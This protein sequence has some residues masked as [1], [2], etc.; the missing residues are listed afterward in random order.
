MTLG[1]RNNQ[2]SFIITITRYGLPFVIGIFYLTA[3]L[4]FEFTADSTMRMASIVKFGFA[5]SIADGYPS[6]LWQFLLRLGGWF[7][8]DPLLTSKV[9]SLVFSCLAV[10]ISYLVANEILRDRL[11]AFCVSLVL[12]MQG[13]LLQIAPSGSALSMAIALTLTALF[14]MLRNEYVVAPFIL[15]LC[16]LV[17][18]QAVFL[19]IP[20]CADIWINSVSKRRASKVM[21]SACLVYFSALMPFGLYAWINNV[22]AVPVLFRIV[23]LPTLS[24]LAVAV[25]VLLGILGVAAFVFSLLMEETRLESVRSN[26]GTL[27]FMIFL[28]LSGTILDLD[29]CCAV[30]P[31]IVVYAFFGLTEILK[32]MAGE[33]LLYNAVFVLTGLL[34]VHFQSD[35]YRGNKPSM[36]AAISQASELRI[37]AEWIKM[38]ASSGQRVCAEQPGIFEYYS[39]RPVDLLSPPGFS[40]GDFMV[41]SQ[42][43]VAGYEV[44]FQPEVAPDPTGVRLQHSVVWRRK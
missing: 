34:L 10:F 13:W 7:H 42:R 43:D 19:L 12:A 28:T 15:G 9:L 40:G 33:H 21:V 38:N 27:L 24:L 29:V 1:V 17:F 31:L 44:A 4:G 39:E 8:L 37:A 18:W 36:A 5:S 26:A 41:T 32:R 25:L 2:P 35:F 20:L 14:F 11:V 16:T 30:V 3:S 22:A 6:P 23:E